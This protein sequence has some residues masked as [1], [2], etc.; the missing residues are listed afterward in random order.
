MAMSVNDVVADTRDHLGLVGVWCR[1]LR[2]STPDQ[3]RAAAQR[4]ESLGYGSL[5]TGEVIGGKDLFAEAA[6][7]LSATKRIVFG[8]GIA[9]IWARH[10]AAMQGAANTIGA[11]WPGRFINGIG[12]SHSAI[13]NLSGQAYGR[14]LHQMRSYL[15]AMDAASADAP[16]TP[17]PVPRLLAALGPKMLETAREHSHGA[18]PYLV[19]QTHIPIARQ[20]LGP[21]RLLVPELKVL[22]SRDVEQARRTSRESLSV[23]LDLPNY[24]RNLRSLGFDEN[25]LSGEGSNRLID[26]LVAWGD[27]EAIATRVR[28][29]R[30][31]GADHVLIQPIA[32]DLDA[33]L[34]MLDR[35][36]PAL[37]QCTAA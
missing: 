19:P 5:W 30:A 18:H 34:I 36:A 4:I 9:N 22:L 16:A 21:Q 24:L 11:A 8:T 26:A 23:Y 2:S 3:S 13:V 1:Q 32:P 27:D 31:A 29:F 14:P 6:I 28:D 33:A 17:T 12:V 10:P 20:I 7:I 15:R 25:D 37:M 35:L